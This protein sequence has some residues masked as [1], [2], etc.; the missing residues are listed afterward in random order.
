MVSRIRRYSDL[1]IYVVRRMSRQRRLSILLLAGCLLAVTLFNAL[2]VVG[3]GL[4]ASSIQ[5]PALESQVH[6]VIGR[7]GDWGEDWPV[8]IEE[9]LQRIT[10]RVGAQPEVD[11][12]YYVGTNTRLVD[13]LPASGETGAFLALPSSSPLW[14]DVRVMPGS[15][16]LGP[17]ETYVCLNSPHADNYHI[18]DRVNLTIWTWDGKSLEGGGIEKESG[19]KGAG[20]EQVMNVT[21]RVAGFIEMEGWA[22]RV[23]V[24]DLEIRFGAPSDKPV[25][26]RVEDEPDIFLIGWEETFRPLQET[27][28]SRGLKCNLYGTVLL[29]VEVGSVLNPADPAASTIS[30]KWLETRIL[31]GL[32]EYGGEVALVDYLRRGLERVLPVAQNLVSAV[33]LTS[34]PIFVLCGVLNYQLGVFLSEARRREVGLL[35]SRGIASSFILLAQLVESLLLA[36]LAF[37]AGS[38]VGPLLGVAVLLLAGYAPPPPSLLFLPILLISFPF[39]LLTVAP[40]TILAMRRLTRLY[41]GEILRPKPITGIEETGRRDG[42]ESWSR[43]GSRLAWMLLVL[44]CLKIYAGLFGVTLVSEL[45]RLAAQGGM[46][47]AYYLLSYSYP[48]EVVFGMVAPALLIYSVVVLAVARGRLLGGVGRS[49]SRRLLGPLGGLVARSSG[50]HR[51]RIGLVVLLLAL[52]VSYTTSTS[53]LVAEEGLLQHRYLACIIGADLKVDLYSPQDGP[54]LLGQVEGLE[55]V[56]SVTL[57]LT[58][59]MEVKGR[60]G[61]LFPFL[62]VDPETWL[63]T[64]YYE[65][66]WFIGD[67][68][69]LI[70]E[71]AESNSSLLLTDSVAG[72][73]GIG[74]GDSLCLI[75]PDDPNETVYEMNIVGL[76]HDSGG[77]EF[78]LP[79]IVSLEFAW[80]ILEVLPQAQAYILV[81][82]ANPSL[83]CEVAGEIGELGGGRVWIR[84]LWAELEALQTAPLA[85]AIMDFQMVGVWASLGMVGG[86]SLI[87]SFLLLLERRR[88]LGIM[89]ARGISLR[90]LRIIP[91]MEDAGI[92]ALSLALGLPVGVA[93]ALQPLSP[94][95]P[96]SLPSFKFN[97]LFM[98]MFHPY[99]LLT[100]TILCLLL[101]HC[102]SI[103]ALLWRRM[104]LKT[105]SLTGAA[106]GV[107]EVLV[108]ED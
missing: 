71:L 68:Q 57:A 86:G 48:L 89:E 80:Q 60:E 102:L 92:A 59:Q 95:T 61:Q 7:K 67:P 13:S 72:W 81:R 34:I 54:S 96:V 76:T 3:D 17:N 83:H 16:S 40:P 73:L 1:I 23:A 27:L 103:P 97:V 53:L 51:R 87:L 20:E 14:K 66:W 78:G 22:R 74:V 105:P 47:A 37:T 31:A 32:G 2:S 12:A 5:G 77:S 82:L 52:T 106:M 28:A 98:S 6:M 85:R 104:Q 93:A 46:W 11:R 64:A 65:D 30:L 90:R 10:S 33:V 15:G 107:E 39:C 88:E 4:M 38:I 9:D 44:S 24:G 43:I 45:G 84:S 69:V 21:L 42:T 56:A 79:S 35:A 100:F 8:L 108:R 75:S 29:R 25:Y 101:P 19:M 49:L 18:G 63:G 26:Q 50:E 91:L 70:G 58:F 99:T 41:P 94:L 62:A 36:A 55:G